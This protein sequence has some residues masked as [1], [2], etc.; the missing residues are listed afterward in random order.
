MDKQTSPTLL[1]AKKSVPAMTS[2]SPRRGF[3]PPK[4]SMISALYEYY[5]NSNRFVA[6]QYGLSS[7]FSNQF[8]LLKIW[9]KKEND[10]LKVEKKGTST[11]QPCIGE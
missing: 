5:Y 10:Q 9:Y 4:R 11:A 3:E 2:M 6:D 8:H 1:I 7:S